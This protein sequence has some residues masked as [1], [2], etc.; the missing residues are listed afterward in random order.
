VPRRGLSRFVNEAISE[1]IEALEQ[2]EIEAEMVE[3]Y[4]ASMENQRDI[5]ED[6]RALEIDQWPE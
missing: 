5:D 6:W 4:K 2:Q 1:K 3:G